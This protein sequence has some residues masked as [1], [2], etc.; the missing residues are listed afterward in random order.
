VAKIAKKVKFG[1]TFIGRFEAEKD[2]LQEITGYCKKN[3][4]QLG[5]FN[6]IGA[7]KSAKLGYYDQTEKKYVFGVNLNKKL[8]ICSCMGNISLKGEKIMVHAHVNL[9]DLKG[10]CYGG[11]LLE[12]SRIFAAE[13]I[14]QELKGAVLTRKTDPATGL[15]LW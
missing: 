13:F 14:I 8:E 10:R 3:K 7:L 4:I 6:I 1:R 5:T 15:P 2:L 9:A 11:H 12:G